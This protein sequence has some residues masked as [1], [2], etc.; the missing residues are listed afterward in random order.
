MSSRARWSAARERAPPSSFT[1]AA[2]WSRR[3]GARSIRAST[4]RRN[5]STV[6]PGPASAS[7]RTRSRALAA[8]R[9][10][11]HGSAPKA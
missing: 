4:E 3:S 2:S 10:R 6:A 9:N 7:P 1:T 8:A 5:A 11:F